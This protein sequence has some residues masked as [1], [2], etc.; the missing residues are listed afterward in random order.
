MFR[1]E[2]RIGPYILVRRLGQG[3]FGEVWLAEKRSVITVTQFA[4]K[5]PLDPEQDLDKIRQEAELWKMAGGH[6]NVL[7]IIEAD[8]LDNQVVIVSEYAPEGSLDRWLARHGGSAP[9]LRTAVRMTTGILA[10]LAH[11][12]SKKIIH[13]D[14]KPANILLQGETPRIA[15]FGIARIIK[16]GMHSGIATGTIL[17][18]AP[19]AFKGERT[20]QTDLWS[21][22]VMLYQLIQGLTPFPHADTSALLRAILMDDPTPLPESVPALLRRVVSRALCKSQTERFQTAEQMLAALEAADLAIRSGQPAL[23]ARAAGEADADLAATVAV[24]SPGPL[25]EP[26]GTEALP[27]PGAGPAT[28]RRIPGGPGLAATVLDQPV[29]PGERSAPVT[30]SAPKAAAGSA[31]PAVPASAQ[32]PDA[33]P[34]TPADTR[35][36]ACGDPMSP[37]DRFCNLCG[38]PAPGRASGRATPPTRR[39]PHCQAAI[40]P[41]D[42][43]CIQCGHTTTPTD[44]QPPSGHRCPRCHAS[45]SADAVFCNGC[46][47]RITPVKTGRGAAAGGPACPRCRMA[48]PPGSLFC[49]GCGLNLGA[50]PNGIARCSHCRQPVAPGAGFCWGCGHRLR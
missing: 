37:G 49:A 39:C 44:A 13:R 33:A 30:P 42:H 32:G 35:C 45:I 1:P 29:L 14:L 40:S 36:T 28:P 41:G 4:L 27:P 24:T 8:I 18:M 25:V 22:G 19:E 31:H 3:G 38:H 11:L 34:A 46:G 15:D 43:F 9:D 50:T 26:A 5:L 17:Y 10:G 47:Q 7:P 2:D 16:T 12:H 23:P 48:L 20:A 6:P 21:V